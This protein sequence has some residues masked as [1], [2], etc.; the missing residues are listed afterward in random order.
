M[1]SLAWVLTAVL[2]VTSCLF[3][4]L[5][6][7][8]RS[9]GAGRTS[10]SGV[11]AEYYLAE[12]TV[13]KLLEKHSVSAGTSRFHYGIA[14]SDHRDPVV[15]LGSENM[16]H[17]AS[18]DH[19]SL[20]NNQLYKAESRSEPPAGSA[21]QVSHVSANNDSLNSSADESLE[22]TAAE[23][24]VQNRTILYIPES[25]NASND[26]DP[27]GLY[28]HLHVTEGPDIGTRF[29]LPFVD[30]SIGRSDTSDICLADESASRLN[31]EIVFERYGFLLRDA[32]S[33]NGTLCNGEEISEH[34]LEF[35]DEI[36]IGD[37]T[38]IFTTQALELKESD[39]A[40]AIAVLEQHLEQEPEFLLAIKNLAFLLERDIRRKSEADPLWKEVARLEKLK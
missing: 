39:P 5:W 35:G 31:S 20:R 18:G 2:A 38:M 15:F 6:W 34:P 7:K 16:D 10:N 33:T 26:V 28:P 40:A 22:V 37:T 8:S 24:D 12:N 25:G 13:Y 23:S 36:K 14:E 3:A 32:G 11:G 17:L 1:I 19:F 21:V 27:L 30:S 29:P 4:F 9:V